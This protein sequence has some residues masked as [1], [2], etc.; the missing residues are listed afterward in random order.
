MTPDKSTISWDAARRGLKAADSAAACSAFFAAAA[1]RA[2]FRSTFLSIV[3][4]STVSFFNALNM[5]FSPYSKC[6]I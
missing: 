3:P 4:L 5:I 1:R 2:F 6:S